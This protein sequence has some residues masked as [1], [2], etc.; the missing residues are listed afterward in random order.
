MEHNLS[1]CSSCQAMSFPTIRNQN[2]SIMDR[3]EVAVCVVI[4]C[5]KFKNFG[6]AHSTYIS[7]SKMTTSKEI[8]PF[9]LMNPY[10]QVCTNTC[11]PSIILRILNNSFWQVFSS[12]FCSLTTKELES[13]A[14]ESVHNQPSSPHASRR[15]EVQGTVSAVCKRVAEPFQARK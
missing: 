5:H 3:K 15:T 4:L 10:L 1:Y 9:S 13:S 6:I 8:L 11:T 14:E 2:A 12:F 7:T